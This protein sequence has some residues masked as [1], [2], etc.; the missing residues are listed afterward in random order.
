[1][2][3]KSEFF[4]SSICM[5]L[6][7]TADF[8]AE[9]QQQCTSILCSEAMLP[10]LEG[11][12]S[13]LSHQR[14]T[15]CSRQG[16][17]ST[18]MFQCLIELCSIF[19]NLRLTKPPTPTVHFLP[20]KAERSRFSTSRFGNEPILEISSQEKPQQDKVNSFRLRGKIK[21]IPLNGK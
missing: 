2:S 4:M 18:D 17:E 3:L 9:G 21:L 7:F 14:N 6:I 15:N 12:S 19:K 11:I 13:S 16:N 10:K 5:F 1:M 8:V 20:V